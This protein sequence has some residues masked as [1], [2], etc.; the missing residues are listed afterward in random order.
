ML[1]I[2]CHTVSETQCWSRGKSSSLTCS[3]YSIVAPSPLYR[4]HI[5]SCRT[6]S[7]PNRSHP[8]LPSN[9]MTI[10]Q[11]LP[12]ELLDRVI[13]LAGNGLEKP[14][15]ASSSWTRR[16]SLV[17]KNWVQPG[18]RLAY[19]F[20][21]LACDLH[22][23]RLRNCIAAQSAWNRPLRIGVLDM[24]IMV[25]LDFNVLWELLRGN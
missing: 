22:I 4:I 12:Q 14:T 1:D 9:S 15:L 6:L 13:E 16:V 17:A 24:N 20:V 21:Q 2:A 18:Q 5:D 7:I 3:Q 10:I 25:E 8:P 11:D 19:I 23:L